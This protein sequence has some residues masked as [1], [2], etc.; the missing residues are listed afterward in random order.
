[1]LCGGQYEP[2]CTLHGLH[3]VLPA[4]DQVPARQGVPMTDNEELVQAEPARQFAEEKPQAASVIL[5]D[6]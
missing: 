2:A 4:K 1:M 3:T 5:A 6:L